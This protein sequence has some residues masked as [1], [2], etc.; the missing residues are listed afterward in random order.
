MLIM[1]PSSIIV[2]AII[3]DIPETRH[4]LPSNPATWIIRIRYATVSVFISVTPVRSRIAHFAPVRTIA[5]SSASGLGRAAEL[6]E[7]HAHQ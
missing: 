5:A 2:C 3:G 1:M 7:V 4:S 6:R